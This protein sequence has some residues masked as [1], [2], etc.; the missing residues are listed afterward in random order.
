M[1]VAKALCLVFK[2]VPLISLTKEKTDLM[3]YWTHFTSNHLGAKTCLAL[4]KV[5]TKRFSLDQA[6][7]IQLKQIS[8][9]PTFKA[10]NKDVIAIAC[11]RDWILALL[12]LIELTND[13]ENDFCSV[14]WKDYQSKDD[15]NTLPCKHSFHMTCIYKWFK[16]EKTYC[17]VCRQEAVTDHTDS[18]QVEEEWEQPY[19]FNEDYTE[20]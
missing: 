7:L 17:P 19:E 5:A 13:T 4:Q 18:E 8:K 2:S 20:E 6:A 9:N 3:D 14:C 12:D 16:N 15:L 1:L 10:I 11:Y